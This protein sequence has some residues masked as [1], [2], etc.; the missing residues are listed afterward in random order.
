MVRDLGRMRRSS[1]RQMPVS[2]DIEMLEN[3]Y[4]FGTK[5]CLQ[6]RLLFNSNWYCASSFENVSIYY[7]FGFVWFLFPIKSLITFLNTKNVMFEHLNYLKQ[8]FST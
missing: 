2:E 8:Y 4:S 7:I 5:S 3:K 1:L 6:G